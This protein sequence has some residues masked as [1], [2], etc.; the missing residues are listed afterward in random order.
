MKAWQRKELLEWWQVGHGL[1]VTGNLD[2][3]TMAS[4]KQQAATKRMHEGVITSSLLVMPKTSPL[5]NRI[6]R[7]AL[8][9]E[10][11]GESGGNNAGPYVRALR[12]FCGFPI[13][14][15]GAWCA[16]FVSAKIKRA[17]ESLAMTLQ[18]VTPDMI[19]PFDLSRGAYRLVMNI[20]EAGRFITVPEPG[21]GCWRRKRWFRKREAHV[22]IITGYDAKTD[23]LFYVAGNEKGRV[24]VSS[25]PNGTWRKDL[26]VMSTI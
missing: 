4:L 16:I 18:A 1:P 2:P 7:Y 19:L 20:G 10:G 23:T 12:A 3:K 14:R 17:V 11:R 24:V 22:R 25:L 6:I 15:L 26:E 8:N 21:F 9:D 13:E 5:M